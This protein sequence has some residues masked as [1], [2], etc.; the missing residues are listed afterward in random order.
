MTRTWLSLGGVAVLAI[1]VTVGCRY[2]APGIDQTD[3]AET[4]PGRVAVTERVE[5]VA[6]TV[7]GMT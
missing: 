4:G 2:E 1:G 6:L 3:P 5:T 7:E